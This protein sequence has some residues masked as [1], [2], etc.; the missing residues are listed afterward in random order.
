MEIG[1]IGTGRMAT[2]MGG[3]LIDRGYPVTQ[4]WGRRPEAAQAA[5]EAMNLQA[6]PSV[7]ALVKA[8]G[9]VL[10]A[11]SDDAVGP[12]A[13]QLVQA[14]DLTGK[15]VG[16]LSGSR[17]VRA[18]QPCIEAG[19]SVFGLHPLLTVAEGGAGRT[20]LAGAHFV[21]EADPELKGQLSQWLERL[22]NRISWVTPEKKGLYHLGACLASNYVM[23][24]YHLSGQALQSAGLSAEDAAQALIPLMEATLENY[25][26]LGPVKGLTGPVSRGDTETVRLHLESLTT[27]PWE[28]RSGL[29]RALGLEA[30]EIAKTAGTVSAPAAQALTRLLKEEER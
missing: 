18:L 4:L 12:V 1:V 8:C 2:A 3:Y 13:E 30:L 5:A 26:T 15:W 19:A 29:V 16:H 21:A 20:A 10:L 11:V 28:N 7:E 9:L 17:S 22:G 6:A 23:T 25:K 27:A 14:G 24:L